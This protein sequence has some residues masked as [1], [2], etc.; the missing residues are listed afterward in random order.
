MTV[1]LTGGTGRIGRRVRQR[2]LDTGYRV[3]LLVHKNRP[4]GKSPENLEIVE[5]DIL[6]QTRMRELVSGCGI[7]CHLAASF[8]MFPPL[9][10]ELENN[11]VFENIIRGTFNL[12]EAA[13]AGK[14]FKL[15]LF[16]STDAVYSTGPVEYTSPI[17]EETEITPAKGRFY[18]VAKAVGESMTTNYGKC[19]GL[20]WSIIRINWALEPGELLKIFEYDFWENAVS[21]EDNE[22]LKPKLGGGKGLLCPLS[23][24]GV[25]AV[26]QIAFPDDTADGFTLA[27]KHYDKA[28]NN[29]FNIAAPAPFRYADVIEK[30]AN[31]LD[32]PYESAVV[33]GFEAYEI[34]NAKAEKIL[35]Y[36]PRHTMDEMIDRAL[37]LKKAGGT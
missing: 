34:S 18:A 12:L 7:I 31:G 25:S 36:K 30:V 24:R 2:L 33:S 3:R 5:G 8:D 27:I 16:A 21:P 29:I 9:N 13:K 35:G 10:H 17:T 28:K 19:Y 6:N 23:R 22:R 37:T 11:R 15:F 4:E 14:D 1:F 20:P 32:L 26:D